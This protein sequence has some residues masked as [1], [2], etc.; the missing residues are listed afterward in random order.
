MWGVS[1]V[2]CNS[3]EDAGKVINQS[4]GL[5]VNVISALGATDPRIQVEA[6]W[7]VGSLLTVS[8]ANDLAYLLNGYPG[9]LQAYIE[10]ISGKGDAMTNEKS[11]IG[12]LDNV[13]ELLAKYGNEHS[14]IKVLQMLES[15]DYDQ[16]VEQGALYYYQ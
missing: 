8:S 2:V 3:A 1:N 15:F 7:A 16:L 13:K 9:L 4:P 6:L 12:V 5:L 11:I 10:A 14:P